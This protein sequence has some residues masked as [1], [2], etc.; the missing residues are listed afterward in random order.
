MRRSFLQLVAAFIAWML[1]PLSVQAYDGTISGNFAGTVPAG[2]NWHIT[3]DVN[4]TG[5]VYVEGLLTG[6]DTFRW[7]GNGFTVFFQNGGR[8]DLHGKVKARWGEWGGDT[9]GWVTGDRLAVAPTAMPVVQG[10]FTTNVTPLIATWAGTWS[11]QAR[12]VSAPDVPQV[13]GSIRKPEVVN[14][15]QSIVF[16]N[17]GRGFHFHDS[18]GV[19]SMSDVKF[20]NCGTQGVLG[21]YPVHFHLLAD[22]SRGS[23][24]TRV[25][26]EGGKNHAFVVHGSHGVTLSGCAAVNTVD[27]AYWW[28]PPPA[29]QANSEI[30]FTRDVTYQGCI[31]LGVVGGP[32]IA[33]GRLT[34]FLLD[35]GTGNSCIDCVAA[36]V[37]GGGQSSGFHWP[38]RGGG[39]WA[40]QN[41]V[42]H[43][44]N[45]CGIFTWQNSGFKD[46]LIDGFT[47]YHTVKGIEHGA[48]RSFYTYRDVTLT[49]YATGSSKWAVKVLAL[50]PQAGPNTPQP[51]ERQTFEDVLT[52]G[53]MMVGQHNNAS[54]QPSVMRRCQFTSIVY[55]E[56][57]SDWSLFLFEDCG[58]TPAKFTL[59]TIRP[60]SVIEIRDGGV[61]THRWAAG[62]WS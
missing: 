16:E 56:T 32:G 46:H 45:Q 48:Y 59:T 35:G 36:C 50:T 5:D 30:N 57:T 18:A 52:D 20:L 22:N 14:L 42:A 9:S 34:G 28:D 2:Q 17:L 53:R 15:G 40:F 49:G 1:R 25:V 41:G 44:N 43:N 37:V 58:F 27:D 4:Q 55:N 11:A 23:V 31:A 19:Q 13:G 61:L 29:D 39:V 7:V 38:E 8:A 60:Q 47:A 51:P 21:N 6:V 3:G 10:S 12:P 54:L 33:N 26:V 24:L 62:V